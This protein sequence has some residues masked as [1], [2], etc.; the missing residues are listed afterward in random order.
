M[1][2]D[3]SSLHEEFRRKKAEWLNPKYDIPFD[4]FVKSMEMYRGPNS[5]G[6]HFT[7]KLI[8]DMDKMVTK[9]DPKKYIGDCTILDKVFFEMKFSIRHI[10]SV[11]YEN[12]KEPRKVSN[13]THRLCN[14]RPWQS[15][16]YFVIGLN[17]PE[18]GTGNRF[19]VVPKPII[20]E[21]P[22]LKLYAQNNTAMINDENK[23]VAVSVSFTPEM[24]EEH[25]FKFNILKDTSYEGLLLFLKSLYDKH[26]LKASKLN[27][28][29]KKVSRPVSK[30]VTNNRTPKTKITFLVDGKTEINGETNSETMTNLIMTLMVMK[31]QTQKEL[32]ILKNMTSMLCSQEIDLPMMEKSGMK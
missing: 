22:N 23:H 30:K 28:V 19:C 24:L 25:L 21:N 17:D 16:D 26:S 7:K 27:N 10:H 29:S 4:E 3:L 5:M 2:K 14:I 32:S 1:K 20:T 6:T 11:K 15:F 18:S 8:H 9:I 13:Y 12:K 31:I